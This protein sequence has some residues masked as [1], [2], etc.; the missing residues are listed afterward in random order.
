MTVSSTARRYR[1]GWDGPAAGRAVSPQQNASFSAEGV[2]TQSLWVSRASCFSPQ[3]RP[4]STAIAF[5]SERAYAA[6]P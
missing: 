6:A 5:V 3:H 2:G 1:R 4:R